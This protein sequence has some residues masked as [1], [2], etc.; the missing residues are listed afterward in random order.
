MILPGKARF[1][2]LR[3]LAPLFVVWGVCLIIVAFERDLGSALL[4]YTIFLIMLYVA[5]GRFSYVLIGIVLFAIGA[6]GMYQV[7]SHVQTR[8]AIWLDPFSDAQNT[9]Y[10]LVQ[11][12][13]SLA[14]GGLFGVGLGNSKQKY[15]YVSEPQNDFI[16]AIVCEELG[17]IGAVIIILLFAALIVRAFKIALSINDKFASLVVI[18]IAAQL[19]VQ[20]ALN[21]LVV[22]DSIPNTGI[23]LPFF[24][25]GGTALMMIL[26]EMGVIL[27]ISRRANQKKADVQEVV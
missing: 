25:Y 17:F 2:R 4:F 8:V 26:G 14:D 16:F 15:L 20:V 19:G 6:F 3:L 11:T 9:G 21:I 12:I 27:G 23:S 5:T 18:G 7:M 13:Y 1:P 24:S 22:T 10:Q